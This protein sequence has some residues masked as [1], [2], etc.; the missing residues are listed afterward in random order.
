MKFE[1]KFEDEVSF[2]HSDKDQSVP[3]VHTI[4]LGVHRQ[5]CPKYPK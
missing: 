1:V 5:A 2:W 3:Q 4:I